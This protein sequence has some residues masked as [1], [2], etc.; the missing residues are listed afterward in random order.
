MLAEYHPE[1]STKA[2]KQRLSRIEQLIPRR[3]FRKHQYKIT[4]SRIQ[5]YGH[6][7]RGRNLGV[8]FVSVVD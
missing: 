8:L 1:E 4:S 6:S 5:V 2:K 3:E 7:P